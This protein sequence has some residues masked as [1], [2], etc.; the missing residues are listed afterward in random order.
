MAKIPTALHTHINTA[1]ADNAVCLLATVLQDGFPQVSPRGSMMVLDDEHLALWERSQGTITAQLR[2][3]DKVMVYFR[4]GE[5][6][7]SG[8]LPL[9]GI[10]RFYGI[11]SVLKSGP[12]YEQVWDRCV[13]F[14]KGRDPEKKG[15]AVVI[16]V[17]RAE[18]LAG[19]PLKD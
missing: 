1:L 18:D 2:D 13:P 8:L 9:G 10:A 7:T 14:E 12:V 4:N 16:K 6:R 3:G 19:K 15:F 5:L 11:A 17:E